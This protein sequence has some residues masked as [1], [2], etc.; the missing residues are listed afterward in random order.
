[1]PLMSLTL[2]LY[3]RPPRAASFFAR[4][5][6]AQLIPRSGPCVLSR[7][8]VTR[9]FVCG[10]LSGFS[11]TSREACIS[12]HF[13]IIEGCSVAPG[14]VRPWNKNRCSSPQRRSRIRVVPS[15]AGSTPASNLGG[16]LGMGESQDDA[17]RAFH[18]RVCIPVRPG[19]V[20]VSRSNE[21]QALIWSVRAG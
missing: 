11:V 18:L 15:V 13:C 5:T 9:T 12:D 21:E 10:S 8:F 17:R 20:S 1:M 14:D 19:G 7:S 3:L 2:L 4:R 16:L 6:L